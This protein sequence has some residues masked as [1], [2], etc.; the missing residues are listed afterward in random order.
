MGHSSVHGQLIAQI[1]ELKTRV[2]ELER[3]VESV[4]LGPAG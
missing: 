3:R 2:A 4:D 1:Q